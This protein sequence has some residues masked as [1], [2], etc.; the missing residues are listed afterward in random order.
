MRA[1]RIRNA[2]RR[3]WSFLNVLE[4]GYCKI[5]WRW[6]K[7]RCHSTSQKRS[8]SRKSGSCLGK[9]A[10][11]KCGLPLSTRKHSCSHF[12]GLEWC[13]SCWLCR[14]RCENRLWV[15]F[16][17]C[18]TDQKAEKK[19]QSVWSFLYLCDNAPVHSFTPVQCRQKQFG[20]V[21]SQSSNI[22]LA[23]QTWPPQISFSSIISRKVRG[24]ND[25]LPKKSWRMLSC[26]SCSRNLLIFLRKSFRN[27]FCAGKNVSALL[28]ITLKNELFIFLL[29]CVSYWKY[30][31]I[32]IDY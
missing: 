15:L 11:R 13:H 32:R 14:F 23:V 27:W 12:L 28:V 22:R 8:V 19:K 21:G 9:D 6:T 7:L 20:A 2:V 16:K 4:S 26:N 24:G 25:F 1:C 3:I 30:F 5:L 18:S 29:F 17:T 31:L 10:R